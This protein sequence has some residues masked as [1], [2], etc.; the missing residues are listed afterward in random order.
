MEPAALLVR[1][2]LT[3]VT[4]LA[5]LMARAALYLITGVRRQVALAGVVIQGPAAWVSSVVTVKL[6]VFQAMVL[7]VVLAEWNPLMI[8][9]SAM[10]DPAKVSLPR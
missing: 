6:V 7:L 3:A 5:E 8:P 2:V 10:A 4:V 1:T 9:S